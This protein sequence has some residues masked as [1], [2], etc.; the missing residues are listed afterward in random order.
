[1]ETNSKLSPEETAEQEKKIIDFMESKLPFLRVQHEYETLM[2]EI[3]EGRVRTIAAKQAQAK[4][5]FEQ[6]QLKSQASDTGPG[7]KE[8]E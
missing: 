7:K 6:Q 8:G 5:H 3:E 2:A 4:W 1:M